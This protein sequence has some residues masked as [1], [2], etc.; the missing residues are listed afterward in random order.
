MKP[1][2]F[3]DLTASEKAELIE[4]LERTASMQQFW[5]IINDRFQLVT[6]IPATMTKKIVSKSIVNM[7]LPMLN[8]ILKK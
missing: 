7:V 5:N 1:R 6:C 8:P 3:N 4:A 2:T